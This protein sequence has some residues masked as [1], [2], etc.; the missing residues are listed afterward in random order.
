M[1][2][3]EYL[4]S[5]AGRGVLATAGGDG[6]VDAALYSVPHVLEDGV[7]AFLMRDRLSHRNIQENPYA[8]FLFMADGPGSRGVRLFLK[9][10]KEETDPAAIK[11]LMRRHLT[12]EE[13]QARG[14]TFLVSFA[15]E[16]ILPLIGDDPAKIPFC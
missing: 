11:S 6:R 15:V 14:M 9:K 4:E 7:V 12:P 5:T 13:D 3:K 10:I 8:T 2:M 16:K 1:D